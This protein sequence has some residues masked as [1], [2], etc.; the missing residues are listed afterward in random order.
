[1]TGKCTGQLLADLGITQSL[2]RPRISNDNPYSEAQFKTVKYHPGFPGR[3]GNI[4]QAKDFCREFFPWYNAEHR[5]GGIGLL[6]PDQVHFRPGARGDPAEAGCARRRLRRPA[7]PLR[8]RPA[9][10]RRALCGGL[11]QPPSR[12]QSSG[13]RRG[14]GGRRC[15]Q[16][17]GIAKL[18]CEMSQCRWQVPPDHGRTPRRTH[19]LTELQRSRGP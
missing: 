17:G 6:T 10:C 8:G 3:F 11:D 19:P 2:S 15:C 1:M 14:T 5:H 4:E 9:P 16:K 7:R 12:G 13:W 18:I